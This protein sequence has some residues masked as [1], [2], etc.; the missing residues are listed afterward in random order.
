MLSPWLASTVFW[1]TALPFTGLHVTMQS[2]EPAAK[3]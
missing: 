2:A 1:L 3:N